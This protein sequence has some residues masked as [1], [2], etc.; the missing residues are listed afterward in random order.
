MKRAEYRR[1]H[2]LLRKTGQFKCQCCHQECGIA[3]SER[4]PGCACAIGVAL[5]LVRGKK[6][7]V[8]GSF[9]SVWRR[10][11]EA[12]ETRHVSQVN[13]CYLYDGVMPPCPREVVI[14]QCTLLMC[15]GCPMDY[16]RYLRAKW[17]STSAIF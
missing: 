11:W 4:L 1:L 12:A 10:T 16:H 17:P 3:G 13:F 8:T 9:F 15:D 14:I 2:R 7:W 6:C 5:T